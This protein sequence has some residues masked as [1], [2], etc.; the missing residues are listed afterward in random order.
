DKTL[1]GALGRRVKIEPGKEAQI[2][3]LITWCFP[4]FPHP[5]DSNM[6]VGNYYAKQF[7]DAGA[8]AQYIAD[9]FDRLAGQT[10]LWHDTWYNSTLPYWFLDRTFL[11]TSI[12]ATATCRR[13]RDGRF[14][15]WE[16]V[17]CCIGTCT[18]VWHYAHAVARLFPDLERSTREIQDLDTGF[19]PASGS[20][21]MRGEFERLSATDGQTGTVLRLYREHQ[22]SADDGFLNRN[23]PRIKQAVE[24]LVAQDKND[25]G[26]LEGDQPN[27]LDTSY[28]G[29]NS[30]ISSLYI[31][32]AR[33]AEEMA[34][35]VGDDAFAERLKK[36]ADAGT[37]HI[38]ERLWNGE[39]F[40]QH[41]DP[42]H[43]D[44]LK[45]G[46]GCF[47]DQVFGQSWAWQ[48]GLGRILPKDK[49]LSALQSLWKYNFTPDVGP[50]RAVYK[51]GR[52]YAMPGEAGLIMCTWP[53][54]GY[55]ESRGRVNPGF[56]AYLNECMNGFEYQVAGHMI[57]EGMLTEG[58]AIT[59]ALHDRYAAS[60]RN[61]WNEIECGDHYARS[62]ASYGV[63]L[64]LCGYEH[65]GP[66]GY[67]AFA[68]RLAPENFKA[69]FTAATGWGTFEQTRQ[70]NE[71]HETIQVKWGRVSLRTLRFEVAPGF[72]VRG[73]SVSINGKPIDAEQNTNHQVVDVSFPEAVILTEGQT[74]E[75]TIH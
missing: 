57:W 70:A 21:G 71:Q 28:F 17:G 3:F 66:K 11:N 54:G 68:P 47:I 4:N 55:A 18:H 29:P 44:A 15:C 32:S 9:H 5:A 41:P 51:P 58:L 8:V 43:P 12:L 60:K 53:H 48:V 65:H 36:I 72:Q 73:V 30:M 61:P 24:F 64:A 7:P 45:T 50:Y 35:E 67:L 63:F 74:L 40:V 38:S 69:P 46:N 14:W 10:R 27:T 19:N 75:I 23:W 42:R 22:M 49:T 34:W 37:K 2:T 6:T 39:Y 20:I 13:W 56:A 52:W 1:R 62:M 33:A 59:R 31:A 16:G 26:I 25:D